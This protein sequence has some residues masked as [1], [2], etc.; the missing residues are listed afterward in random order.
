MQEV[1]WPSGRLRRR[2]WLRRAKG[3]AHSPKQAQCARSRQAGG[4]VVQRNGG[5]GAF[6]RVPGAWRVVARVVVAGVKMGR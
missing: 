5:R 4:E 6:K 1:G 3:R 2:D